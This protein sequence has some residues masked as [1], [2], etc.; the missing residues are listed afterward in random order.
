M[1]TPEFCEQMIRINVITL[2]NLTRLIL[3]KMINDPLPIKSVNRYVI[4]L[5]SLSGILVCPYLSAYGATKAYVASL[6]QGL[7]AELKDTCVR[8]QAFTPSLISTNM[9][10]NRS[11]SISTPSAEAYAKS[12]FSMVGVETVGCGYFIHGMAMHLARALPT[13]FVSP[14]IADL[15]LKSKERYLAKQKT[16]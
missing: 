7:A 6:S 16:N 10:G 12:A 15:M 14:L 3:P 9:T 4:N 1:L 2:T 11:T 5:S 8:V 13:S